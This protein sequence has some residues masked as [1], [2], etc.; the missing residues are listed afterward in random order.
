M[1][2]IGLFGKYLIAKA[3]GSGLDPK[4]K[5]FVVRYDA[6]ATHGSAGRTALKLYCAGIR[7]AMPQL[8]EDLS[9]ALEAEARKA[10]QEETAS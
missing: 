8:A 5:Y 4:A 9:A 10:A 2:K 7:F 3:D 1:S 6:G